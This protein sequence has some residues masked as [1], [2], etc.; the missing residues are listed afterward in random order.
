MTMSET[1][2]TTRLERLLDEEKLALLNADFA[3]LPDILARKTDL[4]EAWEQSAPSAEDL[5]SL[6]EKAITNQSLLDEAMAGIRS[7]TRLLAQFRTARQSID[8]YDFMGRRHSLVPNVDMSVEK[9][10]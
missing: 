5:A 4:M 10:A 2:A 8:T 3:K 7:T 6:S 1:E 9:K